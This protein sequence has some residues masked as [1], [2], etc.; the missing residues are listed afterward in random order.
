MTPDTLS[1]AR[2]WMPILLRS[3]IGRLLAASTAFSCVLVAL[4]IFR[5]HSPIFIFMVWNLF[6]AYIPYAL[7]SCLTRR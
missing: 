5:S 6:L 4:R 7:S 1:P 3:E 2:P